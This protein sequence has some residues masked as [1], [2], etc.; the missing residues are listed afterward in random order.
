MIYEEVRGVL[1][2][3]LELVIH[4][5]VRYSGKLPLNVLFHGK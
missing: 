5:A 4:D 3:F 2:M 1:K